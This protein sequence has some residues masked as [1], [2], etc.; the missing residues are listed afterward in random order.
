[1]YSYQTSLPAYKSNQSE[2]KVQADIILQVVNSK[3]KTT[4]KELEQILG[5]PQSTVS[6]RV[7]DLIEDSKI[8]YSGLVEY[9]GRKRKQITPFQ[10]QLNLF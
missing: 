9:L 2:K 7:N 10:K 5:I 4:L 1:M 3:G 6:A 8:M